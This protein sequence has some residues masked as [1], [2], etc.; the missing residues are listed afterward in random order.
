V[1]SG[2]TRGLDINESHIIK[3]YGTPVKM[4]D[5]RTL[6]L[7]SSKRILLR[8]ILPKAI[9]LRLEEYAQSVRNAIISSIIKVCDFPTSLTFSIICLASEFVVPPSKFLMFLA[10]VVRLL[11]TTTFLKRIG[12]SST[13]TTIIAPTLLLSVLPSVPSSSST[14]ILKLNAPRVLGRYK[15]WRKSNRSYV[16]KDFSSVFEKC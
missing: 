3:E 15:A 14:V 6:L 8:P 11:A 5:E 16:I 13:N 2:H 12:G 4:I 9:L 7:S 10:A 1:S